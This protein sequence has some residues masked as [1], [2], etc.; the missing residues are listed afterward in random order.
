KTINRKVIEKFKKHLIKIGEYESYIKAHR[1][2][3]AKRNDVDTFYSIAFSLIAAEK[4]IGGIEWE[5]EK[6]VNVF[7][8]DIKEISKLLVENRQKL[9][10]VSIKQELRYLNFKINKLIKN[11][12]GAVELIKKSFD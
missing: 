7:G 12:F 8:D 9:F 1:H 10:Y 6:A 11:K 2:H 5:V 3:F 4:G